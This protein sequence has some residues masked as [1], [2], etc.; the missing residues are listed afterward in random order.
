LS[1]VSKLPASTEADSGPGFGRITTRQVATG[2]QGARSRIVYQEH[3]SV[4]LLEATLSTKTIFRVIAHRATD[5]IRRITLHAS[6]L[7]SAV[8]HRYLCG[9]D[10][11]RCDAMRCAPHPREIPC[12]RACNTQHAVR[13]SVPFSA[14]PHGPSAGPCLHSMRHATHT[15]HNAATYYMSPQ[16]RLLAISGFGAFSKSPTRIGS[17]FS[18]TGAPRVASGQPLA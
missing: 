14:S 5:R 12:G 9:C 10:A 4:G 16:K 11:M 7:G 6:A 17:R 15:A 2:P 8:Y 18:A 3:H 13:R 1:L